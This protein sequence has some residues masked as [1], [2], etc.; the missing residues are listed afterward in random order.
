MDSRLNLVV[1]F[2]RNGRQMKMPFGGFKKR[3]QS[4]RVAIWLRKFKKV[5]GT[6]P[7]MLFFYLHHPWLEDL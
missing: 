5:N 7:E 6:L 3:L 4:S 2:G 1:E